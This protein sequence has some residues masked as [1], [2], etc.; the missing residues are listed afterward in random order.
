MSYEERRAP[1]I[2]TLNSCSR[3]AIWISSLILHKNSLRPSQKRLNDRPPLMLALVAVSL[4]ALVSAQSSSSASTT[5]IE[6]IEANFQGEPPLALSRSAADV[7]SR[8]PARPR[9]ARKLHSRRDPL[10]D[11]WR[12]SHHPWPKPL[13]D[14]CAPLRCSLSSYDADCASDVATYPTLA[15]SPSSNATD[16]S[17]TDVRP[18]PTLTTPFAERFRSSRSTPSCWSTPTLLARTSLPPSR[19]AIGSSTGP[20]SLGVRHMRSITPARLQCKLGSLRGSSD[21]DHVS[22]PT[23]LDRVLPR[24]VGPTGTITS[25]VSGWICSNHSQI[26]PPRLLPALLFHTPF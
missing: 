6:S 15:I 21:I 8:C 24:A 26:R 2:I 10:R 4:L 23:T 16:L 17:T 14:R 22:V 3:P 11:L 1:L 13:P 9:A 7:Q 25:L 20:P 19:R 12:F 18:L 5:D